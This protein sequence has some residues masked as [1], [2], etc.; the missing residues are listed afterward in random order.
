MANVT[1]GVGEDAG[2]LDE[3]APLGGNDGLNMAILPAD[4][5]LRIFADR[6]RNHF[7]LV[8]TAD[9]QLYTVDNGSN[10]DLG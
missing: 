9:G 2:G 7:D 10:A 8:F 4:A 1:D 3:T 6:F 5:P